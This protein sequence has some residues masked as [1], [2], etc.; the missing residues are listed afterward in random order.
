ML[1]IMFVFGTRPEAIKMAPLVL[2]SLKQKDKF[3]VKVVITGQHK[4]MLDEVLKIFKIVPDYD[5]KIMKKEQTIIDISISILEKMDKIIKKE[6][7]EII[8]VHGDTSTAL[9]TAM[10]SFYNKIKVAHIEAGLR[11]YNMYSPFPEEMNRKLISSLT[12]YHFAPTENNK[13]NLL[14]ENIKENVFVTG[15]TVIDAL[16]SVIKENYVFESEILNNIDYKNKNIILLTCH[17]RENLGER[18]KDIFESLLEIIHQN[19]D[20]EIIFPMHK[21]PKIRE[22]VNKVIGCQKQIH[23]IE[24]L[25]YVSFVNLMKKVKLI[26]TDSGGIQE[27]APALGKPVF[28]LRTETERSEALE[29]GTIKLIGVKKNN[30]I[31]EVEEILKDKK[32]YNLMSQAKNPY[33][34]GDSSKKILKIIDKI[35]ER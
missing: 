35:K 7:P 16:F 9:N 29:A 4:E 30:I 3:K 17:R 31:N 25:G 34:V 18:M 8:F 11:S 26:L 15:N 24:P 21:N 23:L 10:V 32:K 22:I 5:L 20:I 1:K 13:Q 33:G 19:K 28:V 27:E 14:K 2:E 6:K 12:T